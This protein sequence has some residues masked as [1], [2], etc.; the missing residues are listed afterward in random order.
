[1]SNRKYFGTDGIRGRV[2]EHPITPDF[3]IKLGWAIGHYFA[4]H[5]IQ[6]II[7][8]LKYY[9]ALGEFRTGSPEA[10]ILVVRVAN[11]IAVEE[12]IGIIQGWLNFCTKLFEELN[13]RVF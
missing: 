8:L 5:N 13:L 3:V 2:G 6:V 12:D 7:I 1:M 9:V 10:D 11:N 4:E